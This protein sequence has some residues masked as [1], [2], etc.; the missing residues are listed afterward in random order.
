MVMTVLAVGG[1]L[2]KILLTTRLLTAH[3]K[4]RVSECAK[5]ALI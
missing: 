3:P 5:S 1:A 2:K 4:L